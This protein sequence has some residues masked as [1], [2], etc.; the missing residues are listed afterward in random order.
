MEKWKDIKGFEGIYQVSNKGNIRSLDRTVIYSDGRKANFKGKEMSISDKT[1]YPLCKMN[2]K[3]YKIHRLVAKAFIPN[4]KNKAEINH[5]DGDKH[6]ND[7][8]NLEWVTREENIQHA[9]A[10]GMISRPPRY[11]KDNPYYNRKIVLRDNT[12]KFIKNEI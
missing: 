2:N 3:T 8:L 9:F 1:D 12:G 10:N 5:K 6:N 4:P 11:G 7:V